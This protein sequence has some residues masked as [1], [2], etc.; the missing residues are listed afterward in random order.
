MTHKCDENHGNNG[1]SS[2]NCCLTGATVTRIREELAN[3]GYEF[4]APHDSFGDEHRAIE[5]LTQRILEIL[6]EGFSCR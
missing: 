6:P 4:R 3:V 1:R 2:V 5:T